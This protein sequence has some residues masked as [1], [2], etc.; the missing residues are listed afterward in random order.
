MA[1]DHSQSSE[2]LLESQLAL[3]GLSTQTA[4]T[5]SATPTVLTS[6]PTALTPSAPSTALTAT[7]TAVTPSCS[8]SSCNTS[9]ASEASTEISVI[10]EFEVELPLT[11][12]DEPNDTTLEIP[13]D[14]EL[15]EL[16]SLL[17]AQGIQY[18]INE[19]EPDTPSTVIPSTSV[20]QQATTAV[21]DVFDLGKITTPPRPKSN[22]RK[23]N[24]EARILTTE[25]FRRYK[26]GKV[27]EKMR[28]EAE[29]E[30]R[31]E[32]RKLNKEKK[33]KA[34]LLK[35]FNKSNRNIFSSLGQNSKA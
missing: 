30:E 20:L 28:M 8:Q 22:K 16:K 14:I 21:A 4:L 27:D 23:T 32:K 31:K 9:A 7:P 3:A 1:K 33:L 19:R 17:D 2:A 25:E 34:D 5:P 13:S 15:K 35:K 12:C 11:A 29:K 18:V 26:K 10:E 6:T 24:P